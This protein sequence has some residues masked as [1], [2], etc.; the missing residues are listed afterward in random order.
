MLDASSLGEFQYLVR[1]DLSANA[2]TETP[3]FEKNPDNLQELDLSR[4]Y[5]TKMNDLSVHR[6]LKTLN[7]ARKPVFF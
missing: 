3:I 1:L 2:L 5:I 6:F 7:I 4:N